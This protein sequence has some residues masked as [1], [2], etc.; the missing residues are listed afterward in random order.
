MYGKKSAE[1]ETH[2]G[3]F[4]PEK[5]YVVCN[6]AGSMFEAVFLFWFLG[7][8]VN[9]QPTG[10]VPATVLKPINA[11]ELFSNKDIHKPSPEMVPNNG[12]NV[13]SIYT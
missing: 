9:C 11:K 7:G 1:G 12:P 5:V 6:P 3:V 8:A 4:L 10:G 2:F 13:R